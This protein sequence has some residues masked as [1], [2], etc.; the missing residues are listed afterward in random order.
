MKA[1]A[2]IVAASLMAGACAGRSAHPVAISQ[3]QD[4]DTS[5]AAIQTEIKQNNLAI[6]DL[7]E[8][9]GWKAAQNIAA[10]VAGLFFFP[11]WAGMD[12]QNSAGVEQ[13]ALQSRND[14]LATQAA[15]KCKSEVVAEAENR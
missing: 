6:S 1:L 12:F 9:K 13:R 15:E 10:G 8:E 11:I 7:S 14:Y 4:K 5:C 2:Y 3:P